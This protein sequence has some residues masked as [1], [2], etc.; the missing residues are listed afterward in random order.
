MVAKCKHTS[1]FRLEKFY[2][3]VH[4]YSCRK[5]MFVYSNGTTAAYITLTC[6]NAVGG[7]NPYWDPPY[8]ND[9]NPFPTCQ[10]LGERLL[11]F[12][13]FRSGERYGKGAGIFNQRA[14]KEQ[15]KNGTFD[16]IE[17]N[18]AYTSLPSS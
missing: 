2:N 15:V 10:A 4:R 14:S 3:F 8:D 6:V 7:G 9:I 12:L 5:G 16:C 18:L 1:L 13:I 17:K 11:L